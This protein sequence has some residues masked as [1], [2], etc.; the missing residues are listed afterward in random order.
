MQLI[1]NPHMNNTITQKPGKSL[2]D[3]CIRE[4]VAFRQS[5]MRAYRE[6]TKASI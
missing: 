2:T 4:A 1:I 3:E 5:L 6:I